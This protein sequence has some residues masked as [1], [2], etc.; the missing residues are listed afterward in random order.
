MASQQIVFRLADDLAE[1]L[2]RYARK[3]RRGRSEILREALE[4]YLARS[5]GRSAKAADRVAHLIGSLESGRPDLTKDVRR[6]V[7]ESL[8]RGR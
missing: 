2:D 7:L 6:H 4:T 3:T 8:A 5:T 1:D